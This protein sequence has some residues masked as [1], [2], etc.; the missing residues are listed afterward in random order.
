[1][2]CHAVCVC[3]CARPAVLLAMAAA[4]TLH[5]T[6][7]STLHAAR[8]QARESF[9]VLVCG[10]FFAILEVSGGGGCRAVDCWPS[11]VVVVLAVCVEGGGMYLLTQPTGL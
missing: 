2:L 4:H 10:C 8:L 9:G 3:V 5:A 11:L 7:L 6:R 1:V